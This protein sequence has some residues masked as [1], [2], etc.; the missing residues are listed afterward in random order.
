MVGHD[1]IFFYAQTDHS[2]RRQDNLFYDF[3]R[4]CQL[5]ARA[6]EGVGPYSDD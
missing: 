5:Q 3:S 2:L 4:V 1:N 6:A